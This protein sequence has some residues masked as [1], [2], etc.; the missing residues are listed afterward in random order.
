MAR[1]LRLSEVAQKMGRTLHA[2]CSRRQEL[3]LA[4]GRAGRKIPRRAGQ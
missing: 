1:T 2:V 3:K 4:D